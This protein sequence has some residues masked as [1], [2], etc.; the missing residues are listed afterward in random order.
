ML[1]HFVVAAL[2][3]VT[4]HCKPSDA[5]TSKRP[6]PAAATKDGPRDVAVL[7]A[8]CFWGVETWMEK[9]PGIVSID[10]GY[11]GGK[12]DRVT[13]EQVSDGNTGHAEAVRI[14]YDPSVITYADLV[15]WFFKIHD[16][17]TKNRQGNDQG[18]QYRSAIFP[19]SRAQHAAAAT[20][21]ARVAASGTWDKPLTTTVEP[22]ATWVRAEDYHQDYLIKHP[23]GYDNHYLR[24]VKF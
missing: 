24:D 8:G 21:M 17:T 7:G 10:V 9:A 1:K 3:A 15:T 13:Y 18:T 20:V 19:Q 12:S 23:G 4:L 14:V 22:N 2:A 16:P 6:K 11:A 5:D